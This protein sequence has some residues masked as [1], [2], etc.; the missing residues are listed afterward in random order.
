MTP[1]NYTNSEKMINV[2]DIHSIYVQDWGNIDAKTT[3]VFL[4]G[5]PGSGC[6]DGHKQIFNPSI[7]RVIFFDQRG[8]GKSLPYGSLQNNDTEHLIK[9]INQ[10]LDEF[11]LDKVVLVGGSWG[12]TLALAYGLKHPERVEA[13]ILRGLFTGSRSE[14]DFINKGEFKH[15]FPEIWDDFLERTPKEHHNDPSKYHIKTIFGD[16]EE[17]AHKS[18]FAMSVLEVS[19]ISLDERRLP[20]DIEGFD[21]ASTKIEL[22]FV[23]NLCFMPDEYILDNAHK[24]KMPVWLV[25]GRYD[26]VCPP[27]TAYKLS[28]SIQNSKLIWT[29]AGHSGGDR[30]NTDATAAIITSFK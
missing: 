23:D 7:N 20:A 26:S 6:N 17:L 22:H 12:S 29:L 14:V 4:H 5:G 10:I 8:S 11:K 13:M 3:F 15:Y 25:Q 30:A 1:D 21:S 18:A 19:V 9:D 24:L 27:V 28:K 2:D 16:D